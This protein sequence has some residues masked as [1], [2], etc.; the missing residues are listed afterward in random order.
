MPRTR[1]SPV[2]QR[3]PGTSGWGGKRD[4]AGRKPGP[5][6]RTLHRAR[7]AH[8]ER[9]PVHLTLRSRREAG[10][11]RTPRVYFALLAALA[12]AQRDGFRIAQYSAQ[13][14]HLHL[15]VEATDGLALERGVRGLLVRVARAVN[16]V[17]GRRGSLWADRYHR[18]DL[19]TPR[20]VRHALAYVLCNARKHHAGVPVLDRCSSAAWF[21]GWRTPPVA[22]VTAALGENAASQPEHV[23]VRA[24]RTWLLTVGWRRH[25]LLDPRGTPGARESWRRVAA[26]RGQLLATA[27]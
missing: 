21:D 2:Q 27:G 7:P 11:L 26:R 10:S 24:A 3:L 25:G 20:E 15:I 12:A 8:S 13:E 5:H 14:D 19:R 18:R 22:A 16:R 9:H 23:P 6:P 1:R 17:I 4:G